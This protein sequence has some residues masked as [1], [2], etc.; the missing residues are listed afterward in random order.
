MQIL[1]LV[2]IVGTDEDR[3]DRHLAI[4]LYREQ[5]GYS[6]AVHVRKAHDGKYRAERVSVRR[7]KRELTLMCLFVYSTPSA[8]CR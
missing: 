7:S 2:N 6:S 1:L 8:R 3:F 5:D 4:K